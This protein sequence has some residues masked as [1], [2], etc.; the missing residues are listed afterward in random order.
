M[1]VTTQAP[2]KHAAWVCQSQEMLFSSAAPALE[3]LPWH[4]I[5]A[6]HAHC[7][8]VP[9]N[10]ARTVRQPVA[11]HLAQQG[12]HCVVP[13]NCIL[14]GALGVFLPQGLQGEGRSLS[15]VNTKQHRHVQIWQQWFIRG[16]S[17][18]QALQVLTSRMRDA[19]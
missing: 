7:T 19:A 10:V 1:P 17:G 16:L 5:Y 3:P 13:S 9:N 12:I 14:V 11:P 4:A 2:E 15:E 6:T 8:A 18:Q